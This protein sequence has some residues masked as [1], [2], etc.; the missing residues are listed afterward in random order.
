[1]SYSQIDPIL[2]QW[3]A[4]RGLSIMTLHR[5]CTVR[6]IDVVDDVGGRF[7]LWVGPPKRAGRVGVHVWD[8]QKR[9][10]DYEIEPEGLADCLD[11]AL[12][13]VARWSAA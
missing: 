9:R 3:A 11:E 4:S 1:M 2:N 8:D 6:S 13:T 12:Q 5:D 7:Q 10:K